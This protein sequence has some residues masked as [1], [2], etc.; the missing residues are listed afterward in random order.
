L[1]T[2]S[3][4][5]DGGLDEALGLAVG[6]WSV[7]AGANGFEGEIA[8]SLGEQKRTEA[9][10]IVGH[11]ATHP[12]AEVGEVGHGLAEEGS[13][14]IVFFVGEQGG[15]GD[16]GVVVDSDVEELPTGAAGFV[17]RVASEAMA[18]FVDASQ[19]LD[20]DLKV[21]IRQKEYLFRNGSPHPTLHL[22]DWHWQSNGTTLGEGEWAY[23][24]LYQNSSQ[25]LRHLAPW[26]HRSTSTMASTSHRSQPKTSHHPFQTRCQQPLDTPQLK[27]WCNGGVSVLYLA[28]NTR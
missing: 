21:R 28:S 11:D 17:L 16:A 18:G 25:R 13:G 6:V 8:A 7:E 12:D 9:R 26:V 15:E 10:P 23:A 4:S 2:A 27:P 22:V 5:S 19:L 24:R 20:V 1:N 3:A 14:G